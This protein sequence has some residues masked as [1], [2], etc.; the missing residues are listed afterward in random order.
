MR[1]EDRTNRGNLPGKLL[2][3]LKKDQDSQL[4]LGEAPDFYMYHMASWYLVRLLLKEA[5][6]HI[7]HLTFDLLAQAGI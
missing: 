1:H 5:T 7:Y 6:T 3:L 4:V 2:L